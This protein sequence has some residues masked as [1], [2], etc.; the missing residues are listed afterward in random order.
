[1]IYEV[2]NRHISLKLWE[3]NVYEKDKIADTTLEPKERARLLMME[4]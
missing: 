3:N 1:M 2:T 4:K